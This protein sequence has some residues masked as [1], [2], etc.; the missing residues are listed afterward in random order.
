MPRSNSPFLRSRHF[1]PLLA[2]SVVCVRD[3]GCGR[4]ISVCFLYHPCPPCEN[5]SS[6]KNMPLTFCYLLTPQCLLTAFSGNTSPGE[7][8]RHL[9]VVAPR[10]HAIKP[11]LNFCPLN[12]KADLS[13]RFVQALIDASGRTMCPGLPFMWPSSRLEALDV[14][15]SSFSPHRCWVGSMHTGLL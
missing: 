10:K 11:L 4:E 5:H 15:A 13:T 7:D 1:S 12:C 6:A 8:L 14:P 2:P 9:A 3:G